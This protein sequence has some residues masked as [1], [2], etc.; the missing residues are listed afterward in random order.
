LQ[1]IQ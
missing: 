1:Q